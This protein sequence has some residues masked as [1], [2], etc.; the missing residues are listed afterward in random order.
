MC[1]TGKTQMKYTYNDVR[2]HDKPGDSWMVINNKVYDMSKFDHPG[3][4]VWNMAFGK[5]ATLMYHSHHAMVKETGP[6]KRFDALLEKYCIGELTVGPKESLPVHPSF[7]TEF[8]RDLIGRVK[9]HFKETGGATRDHWLS[10]PVLIFTIFAIFACSY[11]VAINPTWYPALALGLALSFGHLAAHGLGHHQTTSNGSFNAFVFWILPNLWGMSDRYWEFSHTV[12]HHMYCYN[13]KDYM[14][15]QHVPAAWFRIYPNA[16]FLPIHR[17]Q[18]IWYYLAPVLAFFYGG[19]RPSCAP[20]SLLYPISNYFF[21]RSTAPLPCPTFLASGSSLHQSLLAPSEDGN[22]PRFYS[23]N[24]D[25]L[26]HT[27]KRIIFGN[28]LTL[29]V[30]LYITFVSGGDDP[31]WAAA[32]GAWCIFMS[33]GFQSAMVIKSLL[34]QHLADGLELVSDGFTD[35]DWFKHQIVTSVDVHSWSNFF[36]EHVLLQI[37]HHL[38][39]CMNGFRLREIAPI[40]EEVCIKHKVAFNKF[41]N[42]FSASRSGYK[43]LKRLSVPLDEMSAADKAAAG[44]GFCATEGNKK[45]D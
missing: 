4:R 11:W 17:Y 15:E 16:P 13:D 31:I 19:I 23:V 9:A 18:H 20:F 12:S 8:S 41:Y 27:F 24:K 39:P 25:S 2:E 7:D 32:W 14:V 34:V 6:D 10:V 29:P 1:V 38:F 28:I 40:V 45:R 37:E 42:P 3:G 35:N 36:G 30:F 26:F 5:E 22:G 43:Y 21:Q 44:A 33:F